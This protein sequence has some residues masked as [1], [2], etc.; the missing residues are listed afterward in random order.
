M[1]VCVRQ[2]TKLYIKKVSFTIYKLYP[3]RKMFKVMSDN[4]VPQAFSLDT[5][6]ANSNLNELTFRDG[7]YS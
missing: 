6:D 4:H 1:T 7:D 2:N 5:W 3:N